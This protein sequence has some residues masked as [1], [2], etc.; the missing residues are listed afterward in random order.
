MNKLQWLIIGLVILFTALCA[1]IAFAQPDIPEDVHVFNIDT[2]VCV[3]WPDGSGD[4]YCPC[5]ACNNS[6]IQPTIVP[7]DKPQP[8]PQPT[9][10]PACNRGIGNGSED[11]DPGN[12]SGQGQGAGRQAGEDR[13]EQH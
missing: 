7:T 13:G 1:S 11:C 10:K 5:T 3:V 6:T 4:C 8:T 2:L 12:S 9:S